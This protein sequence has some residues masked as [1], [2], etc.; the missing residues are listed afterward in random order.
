VNAGREVLA[1]SLPLQRVGHG[2]VGEKDCGGRVSIGELSGIAHGVESGSNRSPARPGPVVGILGAEYSE[3]LYFPGNSVC[4]SAVTA[5]A[6]R[7][8]QT[9]YTLVCLPV[10]D[11]WQFMGLMSLSEASDGGSWLAAALRHSRVA[12]QLALGMIVPWFPT[13]MLR[14]LA[15]VLRATGVPFCFEST[16][17]F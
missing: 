14:S 16:L 6:Q 3:D 5:A 12:P 13:W 4:R 1:A 10:P 17:E 15:W 11:L 8:S 7:L 9:G 2:G